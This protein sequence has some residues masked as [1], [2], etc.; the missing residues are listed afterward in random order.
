MIQFEAAKRCF[1]RFVGKGNPYLELAK[2]YQGEGNPEESIAELE[3]YAEI[4]QEDFGVRKELAAWYE[5]KH[6]DAKVIRVS[7]EMIE[8]SPFGANRRKPPDLDLHKR[9]RGGADARR[10]QGG[11]GARVEGAGAADRPAARGGARG[12]GRRGRAADARRPAARARQGRRGAT[13]RRS[14]RWRRPGVGRRRRR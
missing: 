14:A 3:A 8:I 4:A 10:P 5:A 13:S 9:L 12:G 11:G 7:D 2:L 1:P 6:D